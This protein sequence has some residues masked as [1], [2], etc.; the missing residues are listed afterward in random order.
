MGVNGSCACRMGPQF[1]TISQVF[2][3]SVNPLAVTAADAFDPA[4]RN[5]VFEA[6]DFIENE[7]KCGCLKPL[8]ITAIEILYGDN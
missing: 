3:G 6:R 4:F 8:S 7:S 5:C 2:A 1:P